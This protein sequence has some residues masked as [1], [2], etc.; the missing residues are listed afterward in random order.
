MATS[1]HLPPDLI[2]CV[3]QRA[4]AR[5]VSRNRYIV[6][7]LRR[8]VAEDTCWSK[9]FRETFAG[10]GCSAEITHEVDKMVDTIVKSRK[11]RSG[12]AL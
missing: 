6:E 1:V 7:M 12:S 8:A 11:S 2:E 4:K 3:D 5:G 9:E 10:Q